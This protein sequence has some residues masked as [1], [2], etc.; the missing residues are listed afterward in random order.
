MPVRAGGFK[1]I[2]HSAVC[3]LCLHGRYFV[4]VAWCTAV[5]DDKYNAVVTKAENEDEI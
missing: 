4:E 3:L 1:G 2:V 5:W